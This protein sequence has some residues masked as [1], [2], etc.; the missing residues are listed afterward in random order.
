MIAY[1]LPSAQ[2]AAA[3]R[4]CCRCA[5]G[6][7]ACRP[8]A[9]PPVYGYATGDE[10]PNAEPFN[11]NLRNRSALPASCREGCR[12][13]A[14]RRRSAQ[15]RMRSPPLHQSARRRPRPAGCTAAD[16]P[17]TGCQS[18]DVPCNRRCR[19]QL[20]AHCWLQR[21]W[22]RLT[23][24]LQTRHVCCRLHAVRRAPPA[25]LHRAAAPAAAPSAAAS[26]PSSQGCRRPSG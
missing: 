24:L 19:W 22:F 4:V 20:D 25:A 8:L 23:Q 3:R 15:G 12:K 7:C 16:C 10:W 14:V 26:A 5:S 13:Q 17:T 11:P 2:G 6:R 18:A 21:C 1:C 9:A